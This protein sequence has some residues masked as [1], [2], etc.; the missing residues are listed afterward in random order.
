MDLE[1]FCAAH[2]CVCVCARVW[3][4]CSRCQFAWLLQLL[5]NSTAWRACVAM[6]WSM[7]LACRVPP[8]LVDNGFRRIR[9]APAAQARQRARGSGPAPAS[10]PPAEPQAA[11]EVEEPEERRCGRRSRRC[12]RWRSRRPAA[13]DGR[14][15]GRG[16]RG[17]RLRRP[18]RRSRLLGSLAT[19]LATSGRMPVRDSL[20]A[21]ASCTRMGFGGTKPWPPHLLVD[22]IGLP[23]GAAV[24]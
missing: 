7:S 20:V 24:G 18:W 12:G 17:T 1:H 19:P 11:G 23:R 16:A 10:A 4:T 3:C 15:T 22:V 9:Q 8:Q 13:K 5:R 14:L 2:V 6:V 21:S